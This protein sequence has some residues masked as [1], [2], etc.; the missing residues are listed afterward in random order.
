MIKFKKIET[1]SDIPEALT[2]YRNGGEEQPSVKLILTPILI[3]AQLNALIRSLPKEYLSNVDGRK[4]FYNLFVM[5]HIIQLHI[6]K[7]FTWDDD[8]EKG[9]LATTKM[10][11]S[12]KSD[13]ADKL[14]IEI[15]DN[16]VFEQII[17]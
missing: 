6:K 4:Y 12:L 14:Q 8:D 10:V 17:N 1:P 2:I 5:L 7:N 9:L 16:C 3:S 15:P 11:A 13:L